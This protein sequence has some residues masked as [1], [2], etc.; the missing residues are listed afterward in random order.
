MALRG[1]GSVERMKTK[2]AAGRAGSR[3]TP[4][5]AVAQRASLEAARPAADH[6]KSKRRLTNKTVAQTIAL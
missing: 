3:P 4:P 6:K 5:M 2:A 1:N